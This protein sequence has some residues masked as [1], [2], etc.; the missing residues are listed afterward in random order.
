MEKELTVVYS[1]SGKAYAL[2]QTYAQEH[3]T[4]LLRLKPGFD[5]KSFLRY[6]YWGYK[7]LY[8]KPVKLKQVN[9]DLKAYE[10]I[11]VFSPIHAGRICAPIRSFLFSNRSYL[12]QV[13]IVT[14][15]LATD[16]DYRDAVKLIEDELIFKFSEFD[17]VIVQ[18]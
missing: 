14:V 5:P 9:P 4:D 7:A 13:K 17:S 10:R 6:P 18:N 12:N 15:H 8:K 11:T 16:K 1:N 3:Q 2:A